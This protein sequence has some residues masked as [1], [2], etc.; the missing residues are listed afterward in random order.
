MI[1]G[2]VKIAVTLLVAMFGGLA[3]IVSFDFLAHGFGWVGVDSPSTGWLVLGVLGGTLT[4]LTIGLRRA[5]RPMSRRQVALAAVG[6]AAV[7]GLASAGLPESRAGARTG[8]ASFRGT[9]RAAERGSVRVL[10]EE[11]NMRAEPD[12]GALV[13]GRVVRGQTLWVLETSAT[14]DWYRVEAGGVKGWVGARFVSAPM[15]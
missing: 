5:G 9:V 15:D 6:L 3:L 7:L 11:L 2:I 4:G 1:G 13:V 14:G 8:D 10:P 12:V